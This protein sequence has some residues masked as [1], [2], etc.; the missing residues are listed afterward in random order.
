MTRQHFIIGTGPTGE[1]T[2][3]LL[4]QR[5]DP[6]TLVNRSG[7][8][9]AIAGVQRLALDA[10][11]SNALRAATIGAAVIYNCANPS[12]TTWP[13][14][15]PTLASS[16]LNA[17]KHAEARLVTLSNLYGYAP[18]SKP[19]VETDPLVTPTIKGQVRAAMWNEAKKA[20]DAGDVVVTEARGSDF[21]GAELGTAFQMGERVTGP[22]KKGK[23]VYVL[24]NLD[25][26]HS[27]TAIADVAATLVEL[28][29]NEKAWGRAW[30]IPT[31][32]PLTQRQIINR[33]A[34]IAGVG[35]ASVSSAP[36]LMLKLMALF[37]PTIR[38]LDEIMYQFEEPFVVD[39]QAAQD[40]FGLQP[41]PIEESLRLTI[42]KM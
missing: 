10:S 26:P 5:G 16:I 28:G 6:V 36:K 2:A 30:H 19:M 4:A 20:H 34:D 29:A 37:Q 13:T 9:T 25:V 15:W 3:K 14:A 31:A 23:K 21:I 42:G 39:S 18:P 38:E 24:G 35:R 12:Y 7:Q 17:A 27:W 8:G 32:E 41:T 33:L 1:A 11:D 22:L 40:T